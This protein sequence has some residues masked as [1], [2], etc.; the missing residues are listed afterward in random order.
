MSSNFGHHLNGTTLCYTTLTS[1]HLRILFLRHIFCG[2]K[3]TRELPVFQCVTNFCVWGPISSIK[4]IW[5]WNC[6][7]DRDPWTFYNA[8]MQI[9]S[10][11]SQNFFLVLRGQQ[12]WNTYR[13]VGDAF[14]SGMGVTVQCGDTFLIPVRPES[15]ASGVSRGER[16]IAVMTP[17]LCSVVKCPTDRHVYLVPM[18]WRGT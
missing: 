11:K 14:R 2:D 16:E 18:H 9:L 12:H 6:D 15:T 5:V 10:S 17:S 7:Y 8:L 1:K 4:S 3:I 13:A